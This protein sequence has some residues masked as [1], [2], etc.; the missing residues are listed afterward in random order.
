MSTATLSPCDAIGAHRLG[1][2]IGS[3]PSAQL[4][5][6]RIASSPQSRDGR[7]INVE[8]MVIKVGAMMQGLFTR[9][10]Q[11][12]P[13]HPL[14]VVHTIDASA[15]GNSLGSWSA[16]STTAPRVTWF[17]H[18]SMRLEIGGLDVLIDPVWGERASPVSWA[19]P[20]R[21]YA[22]PVALDALPLPDVIVISH[23]H[24][25]HLDQG[26]IV[27]LAARHAA[28]RAVQP[29]RR[30]LRFLVPLGV[31]AHLEHWGIAPE[32]I[33]ECDWWESQ[34]V[35]GVTFTLAPARH[36]SGRSLLDRD[37]TLWGSWA[38]TTA[39]HRVFYS[40][41]S[42]MTSMFH[43]IGE[44]LGPFDVTLMQIGAY[45]RGWPDWH[46][47]PE[48]AILAQEALRAQAILPVHWGLFNLAYHSW[49]D[50]IERLQTAHAGSRVLRDT[51]L[52]TPRPGEALSL[53][54]HTDMRTATSAWWRAR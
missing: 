31:G 50:P 45:D 12:V 8:P 47:A 23:D 38:I 13:S 1:P 53:D 14:P 20:R 18:S 33:T 3:T 51:P 2:R 9:S 24:Y 35:G 17:G 21:W 5:A 11:S 30:M 29:G 16:T 32:Q 7:F 10:R 37:A 28:A 54:M 43:D 44:R 34:Q 49:D 26:T 42:G 36:A 40:G 22:A 25:D 6:A 15:V 39:T 19:G 52:L 48:Q 46:L 27:A 41:D 4:R